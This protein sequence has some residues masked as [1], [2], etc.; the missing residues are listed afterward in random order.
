MRVLYSRRHL[1]NDLNGCG[2]FD[3]DVKKW[4]SKKIKEEE[5]Q[6]LPDKDSA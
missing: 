6:I 4:R 5:L 3:V 1:K 2:E